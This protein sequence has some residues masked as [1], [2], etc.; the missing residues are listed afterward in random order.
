MEDRERNARRTNYIIKR[1][2][3]LIALGRSTFYLEECRAQ[4]TDAQ[5]LGC[6]VAKF[7]KWGAKDVIE[8]CRSALEDSNLD[9]LNQQFGALVGEA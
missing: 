8:A 6:I 5:V 3:D 7:L 1:V 2:G 9:T 4:V